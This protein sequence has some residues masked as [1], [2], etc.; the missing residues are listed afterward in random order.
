MRSGSSLDPSVMKSLIFLVMPENMSSSVP[1]V[2]GSRVSMT[3]G[4]GARNAGSWPSARASMPASS[5]PSCTSRA[6]RSRRLRSFPSR[7]LLAARELTLTFLLPLVF[8]MNTALCSLACVPASA[9]S[10]LGGTSPAAGFPV[11]RRSFS[12]SSRWAMVAPGSGHPQYE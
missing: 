4:T 3:K 11:V 10:R 2:E 7:S 9:S 5:F 6:S 1:S 8:V 12:F